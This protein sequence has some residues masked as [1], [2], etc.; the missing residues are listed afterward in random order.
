MFE[1]TEALIHHARFTILNM[2]N[3]DPEETDQELR[4]AEIWAYSAGYRDFRVG[5]KATDKPTHLPEILIEDWLE[6]HGHAKDEEDFHAE[7]AEHKLMYPDS[8]V[9]RMLYCPSGHNMVFTK[10]HH[11]ECGACGHI[12]TEN[13]EASYYNSLISA[14]QC[15]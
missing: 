12:M 1:L 4:M 6:G 13:A 7:M 3:G 9:E 15:M 5:I 2:T 14:G 11:D 8:P 10:A